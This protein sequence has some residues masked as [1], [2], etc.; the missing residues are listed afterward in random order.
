MNSKWKK[1]KVESQNYKILKT[2]GA[3]HDLGFS[4]ESF[5]SISKAQTSEKKKKKSKFIGLEKKM[6]VPNL[7]L[8]E[9]EVFPSKV[10]K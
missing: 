9:A 5:D 3:Y 1:P 4:N 10:I 2:K 8:R 7:T 6:Q